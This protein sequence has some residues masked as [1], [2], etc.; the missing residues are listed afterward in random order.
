MKW[1]LDEDLS[2]KVAEQLRRHGVDAI[3]A[4]EVSMRGRSDQEQLA[5]ATD[6]GRILVT[7]NVKDYEPL[8]ETWI[9]S[10]VL[11]IV[12]WF[13]DRTVRQHDIGAQVRAILKADREGRWPP[14]T[15]IVCLR[16]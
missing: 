5:W 2:H 13:D 6:H 11:P 4:H 7:F 9:L 8:L 3:S 16:P 1:Y 12:A 14:G 10:G 15:A